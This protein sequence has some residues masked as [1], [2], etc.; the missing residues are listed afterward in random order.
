MTHDDTITSTLH[1]GHLRDIEPAAFATLGND[2]VAYLKPIIVGDKPG[3]EIHAA[4]GRTLAVIHE[5]HD[6]AAAIIR[7][8]DLEPLSLH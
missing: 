6:V 5:S 3:L 8:N 1:G 7:Q 4:D 2:H